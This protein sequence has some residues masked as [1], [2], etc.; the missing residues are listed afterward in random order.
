MNLPN[1]LSVLRIVMIPI[2]VVFF[3]LPYAFSPFVAAG[4]FVLAA[5]TDF[6]DG[7]IARKYNLVTDLGKLLDPIADKL[8][9][10][11]ALILLCTVNIFDNIVSF[12]Y[13]FTGVCTSVIMGR[14][15]L[16]SAIRQIASAKGVIIHANCFGKI[17]TVM[18]DI[19]IV[20]MIVLSARFYGVYS[21]A[22]ALYFGWVCFALLAVS[23]VVT[24]LSGVKYLT[25]NKKVFS[26][27]K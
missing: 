14:E 10:S 23:T 12:G 5:F 17:K 18:Q 6:L 19:T 27:N 2:F 21:E 8:L 25:D 15:L 26:E 1:K 9:V 20:A 16:I 22:V 7:Y 4:V 13:I 11:T 24:I 3:F